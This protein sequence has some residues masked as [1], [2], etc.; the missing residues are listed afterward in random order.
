VAGNAHTVAPGRSTERG[1]SPQDGVLD[2]SVDDTLRGDP[3]RGDAREPGELVDS[4]SRTDR[5]RRRR[6]RFVDLDEDDA[7][8]PRASAAGGPEPVVYE[9]ALDAS[10][11][12]AD[13]VRCIRRLRDAGFTAY[14]VGG[15]VRDLLLGRKPKDFD[16]ATDARPQDV[17]RIFR[18]CRIIGR[19]F[20]LAHILF[21]D[22]KVIECATFRR[23]PD[24]EISLLPAEIADGRP[25]R[26]V[27]PVRLVPL[28]RV[29]ADDDLLIRHDNV[30]GL[31]HEDAVRRD[32]TVNGLFYDPRRN[33]VIDY[34]GGMVDVERR[35]VRTIGEP[36]VRFREDPIRILRAIKF[37]ARLDMGLSPEVYDAIVD[38]RMELA[39]ASKPRIF[40]EVL[41]LLRGGAAM[42]S[43]YLAW[44]LGVLSIVMPEVAA[45]LDDDVRGAA[46]TWARLSAIDA[47]TAREE[48]PTDSVLLAAL[49]LDCLDEALEDETDP[50]ESFDDW[51]GDTVDALAFPR[52]AKERMIG[53]WSSLPRM[54]R[55]RV[56]SLAGSSMFEEACAL[57]IVDLE[58]DG[59]EPPLWA[60]G[61]EEPPDGEDAAKKKRRRR[62]KKKKD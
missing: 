9:S 16:I 33:E 15:G 1:L 53:L 42:R 43:I 11:V 49:M 7:P 12:D 57:F 26:A 58:A 18:N 4:K 44:D 34:V 10:L 17:R 24:Q 54:R 6:E 30:F 8:A 51:F 2:A 32:F 19:R 27:A 59:E 47:R 29:S 62:N 3:P 56:G 35:V 22:N 38:H 52:K 20:R 13:A 41:R 45:F 40:E 14:L 60:L 23:D 55:G 39:K 5:P 21:A 25:H 28:H 48:L 31:P 61:L 37:S 36:A 50:F 46:R